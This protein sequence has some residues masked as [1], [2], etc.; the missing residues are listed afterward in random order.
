MSTKTEYTL[1]LWLSNSKYIPNRNDL[2]KNIHSNT[3]YNS[4]KLKIHQLTH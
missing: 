3:V 4:P 2:Y 1:T